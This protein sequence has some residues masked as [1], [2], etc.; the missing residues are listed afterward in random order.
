[1]PVAKPGKRLLHNVPLRFDL[2]YKTAQ[3]RNRYRGEL[4]GGAAG[5]AA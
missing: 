2:R 1:M 3:D 5:A 4:T